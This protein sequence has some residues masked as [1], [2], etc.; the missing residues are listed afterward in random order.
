VHPRRQS[1]AARRAPRHPGRHGAGTVLYRRNFIQG[2][3]FFFTVTL[4]DR[5]SSL[6]VDHIDALRRALRVTRHER[7]FAIDVIVILPDHLHA[8]FSLPAARC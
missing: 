6:L 2:G 5:R 8:M 1:P 4:V 7:P 3:T